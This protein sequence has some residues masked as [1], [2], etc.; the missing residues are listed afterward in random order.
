M[1]YRNKMLNDLL[2]IYFQTNEYL[3]ENVQ[4]YF[5]GMIQA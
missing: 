1:R 5:W 4:V 2:L 3:P